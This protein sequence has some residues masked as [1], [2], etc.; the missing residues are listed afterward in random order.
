MRI[1]VTSDL[2]GNL[3]KV[4]ECDLLL[5]CGDIMPLGIQMNDGYSIEW[6]QN[7]FRD[8][9]IDSPAKQIVFIAGNHDFSLYWH[10]KELTKRFLNSGKIV[11]LK[12]TEFEY[13]GVKIYGTPWCHKFGNWAF[14]RDDAKLA[15]KYD[16][17]PQN[18]DILISHDAPRIENFGT[19]LD[20][21]ITSE[22]AEAGNSVLAASIITKSP[23]YA[24]CGHIH[25]G[26]HNMHKVGDT[27]LANVSFVDEAYD[28]VN[29]ILYFEY[30]E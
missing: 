17:I 3:P 7:Q 5:I 27:V 12:D 22:P 21:R 10:R 28:P 25:S 20:T 9:C 2:H 4:E 11:Y 6:L 1:A 29:P 13:K 18:V 26:D 24:F 14:M 16:K 8:W 19:I 30:G 23:K 15:E